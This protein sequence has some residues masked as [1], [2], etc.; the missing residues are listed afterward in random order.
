MRWWKKLTSRR[1]LICRVR[2]HAYLLLVDYS[3]LKKYIIIAHCGKIRPARGELM[4]WY[5]SDLALR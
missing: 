1:E 5:G 2:E 3:S 4:G